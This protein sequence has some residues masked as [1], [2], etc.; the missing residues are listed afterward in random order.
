MR[1]RAALA[2][3]AGRIRVEDVEIGDPG[4]GEVLVELRASGICHTDH[5]ILEEGFRGILGHEGAGVVRGVGDGVTALK[6]GDHVLS[7]WAV[8]CGDC[9]QCLAVAPALIAAADRLPPLRFD[10]GLD[11]DLLGANRELHAQLTAAGVAHVYE[12]HP[13]PHDWDYWTVR[14]A[15]T[16]RSF[17]AAL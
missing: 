10:V 6:A 12:E 5:Q 1:G 15:D 11:D 4:P 3:G 2:D 8:F 17:A 7:N 13:G 16:L 14:I 9:L